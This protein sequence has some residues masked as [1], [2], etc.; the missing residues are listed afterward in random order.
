MKT[1]D[2]ISL[3][4]TGAE[5]V[6]P[7]LAS[8]RWL[9]ALAGGMLI[10]FLITAGLLKLNSALWHETSQPMF[11]V[12]ESYCAALSVLGFIAAV[13]LARP[14]S[15]PGWAPWGIAVTVIAMWVLAV[16]TLAAASP[17][18]RVRLVLGSSAGV[19]PFLIALLSAPL[20][21]AL[22][23]VV[24]NLAPTRLRWAGA[25]SGFTA[26]SIGAL[27]YTLHCPELAAPFLG[28]WYLLG[29]LIP[30]AI[31]GWLGPRLLRW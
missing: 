28:I 25:A 18:N 22:L 16:V 11:W 19:C 26:G 29:M 8:R 27:V 1:E 6:D 14:G 21:A 12:R 10:A 23:C 15:R 9:A 13:R 20:L 2:L 4:S 5:A 7:R 30:T 24:R 17:Q 3:L 31:G